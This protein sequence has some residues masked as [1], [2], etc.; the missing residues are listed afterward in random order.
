MRSARAKRPPRVSCCSNRDYRAESDA[1][2]SSSR[3]SLEAE[4]EAAL[5]VTKSTQLIR[6]IENS[7]LCRS[8]SDLEP[9]TRN[10]S[11]ESYF[12]YRELGLD[13]WCRYK[14]CLLR[15]PAKWLHATSDRFCLVTLNEVYWLFKMS[16]LHYNWK[17]FSIYSF[18]QNHYLKRLGESQWNGLIPI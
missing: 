8:M 5:P 9:L 7:L 18:V 10:I 14:A 4:S 11:I 2:Y 17:T 12:C 3:L 16:W 13:V 1:V 6:L 15:D